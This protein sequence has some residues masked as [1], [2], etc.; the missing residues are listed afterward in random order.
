MRNLTNTAENINNRNLTNSISTNSLL[1]TLPLELTND[2]L[3][4]IISLKG[5]STIGSASQIIRV[6][7]GGTAL[8]YHTLEV[9][10]LNS[11]QTVLNKTF[12]NCSLNFNSNQH[13][14]I[15]QND[16]N[17]NIN[18]FLNLN[19]GNDRAIISYNADDNHSIFLRRDIAG[20]DNRISFYEWDTINFYTG[21]ALILVLQICL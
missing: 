17:V 2:G 20:V 8:E 6:N 3:D 16:K 9:V 19:T 1:A 4:D 7:A 18:G 21:N 14:N 15:G 11:T 12:Q 10:D 5:L 13:T